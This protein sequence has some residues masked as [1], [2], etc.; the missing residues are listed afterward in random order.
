M[1]LLIPL[2]FQ[3][4]NALA[5][6]K[7]VTEALSHYG[8]LEN[9]GADNNPDITKWAKELGGW[10][11]TYYTTDSIPWCGLFMAICAKRSGYAPPKDYLAAKSWANFGLKSDKPS[12]GDILVFTRDGGNHVA[13]YVSEDEKNFQILGGNQS[14]AVKIISY[15]K[16]RLLTA[17]T[18][19]YKIARPSTAVPYNIDGIK[20]KVS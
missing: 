13:L 12:L 8:T 9:K 6:P 4:L 1:N 17:R 3:W 18:P 19:I 11:S 15:P 2:Q 14:D 16:S 10:E 5:L 20:K 7:M